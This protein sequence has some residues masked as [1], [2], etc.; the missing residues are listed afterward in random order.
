MAVSS[1]PLFLEL[2]TFQEEWSATTSRNS[3]PLDTAIYLK[4]Q[5]QNEAF[6]L[7]YSIQ[8]NDFVTA[9]RS[10]RSRWRSE[11]VPEIGYHLIGQSLGEEGLTL[12]SDQ[13][14][15]GLPLPGEQRADFRARQDR[16][17]ETD[18]IRRREGF[19]ASDSPGL[20]SFGKTGT[21]TRVTYRGDF[22]QE[23]DYPFSIG[24]FRMVPYVMGRYTWYSQSPDPNES[25]N[26]RLFAGAACG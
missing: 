23:V 13:H 4:H 21:P 26:D 6:T 7:L 12:F 3:G 9:A 20:P 22:R 15:W 14:G 8:P 25:T 16:D 2:R 10:C 11:R 5:D 18:L 19:R 17:D 24:Q 1:G